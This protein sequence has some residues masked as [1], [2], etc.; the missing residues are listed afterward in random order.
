MT[1]LSSNWKIWMPVKP[2]GKVSI[3][4][5]RNINLGNLLCLFH[6]TK[7]PHW[8]SPFSAKGTGSKK[9]TFVQQDSTQS[10]TID[11]FVMSLM[12][13]N[14]GTSVL[15]EAKLSMT[16]SMICWISS[17][18][19]GGTKPDLSTRTNNDLNPYLFE[20]WDLE[21]FVQDEHY[22]IQEWFKNRK[23]SI[24]KYSTW[25]KAVTAPFTSSRIARAGNMLWRK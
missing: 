20:L 15:A 1:I 4:S 16:N 21:F 23:R 12:T 10:T 24:R 17:G 19:S 5:D 6:L 25:V 2:H 11:L 14:S 22:Y 7:L 8:R 18:E 9:A 13:E 3:H